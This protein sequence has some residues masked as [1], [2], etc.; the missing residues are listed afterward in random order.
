MVRIPN[1]NLVPK[2]ENPLVFGIKRAFT[3]TGT[4]IIEK[5]LT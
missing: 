2:R 4:L 5:P 1:G 3:G